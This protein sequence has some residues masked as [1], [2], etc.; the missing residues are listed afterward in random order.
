M[1][2]MKLSHVSSFHSGSFYQLFHLHFNFNNPELACLPKHS[3]IP[4]SFHTSISV[5]QLKVMGY[6][7][8]SPSSIYTFYPMGCFKFQIFEYL[9][10]YAELSWMTDSRL[11]T[12]FIYTPMYT[13]DLQFESNFIQYLL[14]T[15][16][17]TATCHTRLGVEFSVCVIMLAFRFSD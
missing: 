13:L 5:H 10:L 2:E 3:F 4:V 11:C 12:K 16:L 14:C 1:S 9:H 17:L 6:Y 8:I 7:V 15:Y